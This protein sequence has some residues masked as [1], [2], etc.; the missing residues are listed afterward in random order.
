YTTGLSMLD[1]GI[2]NGELLLIAQ[3]MGFAVTGVE[4]SRK[5]ASKAIEQLDLNVVWSDFLEFEPDET[6]DVITMGDIIEHVSS[7]RLAL[8]KAAKL[9]SK[10][11]ILWLSTPNYNSAFSKYKLFV[12]PMWNEPWHYTYFSKE[13]LMP[14]L[15]EYGFELLQYNVS[16]RYNGSMELILKK[17]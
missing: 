3:E 1:V 5:E 16:A 6:F 10:N 8:E 7:P 14:Y 2:G 4:I 17:V 9:L 11:G 12:D 13:V 15:N